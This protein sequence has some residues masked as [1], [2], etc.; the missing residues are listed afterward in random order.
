MDGGM[1]DQW[2]HRARAGKRKSSVALR[3]ITGLRAPTRQRERAGKAGCFAQSPFLLIPTFPNNVCSWRERPWWWCRKIHTLKS[4]TCVQI[5]LTVW[6][7]D[8]LQTFAHLQS[9]LALK[10]LPH[11]DVS[12]RFICPTLFSSQTPEP[13]SQLWCHRR[14][15]S[16][17]L[18]SLPFASQHQQFLFPTQ[19]KNV[20]APSLGLKALGLSLLQHL[21][22]PFPDQSP[23]DSQRNLSP[24]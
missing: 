11:L 4:K 5:L 13:S 12:S 16:L 9:D 21:F 6:S 10:G 23:Q 1:G 15:R 2:F 18:T 19:D 7:G 20:L 3:P 14:H 22:L 24:K 8:R 17:R